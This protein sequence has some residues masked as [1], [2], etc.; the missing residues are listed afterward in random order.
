[1]S[2]LNLI[3][4]TGTTPLF[5]ISLLA[6][7]YTLSFKRNIGVNDK[8]SYLLFVSK[9]EEYSWFMDESEINVVGDKICR[10]ILK[11]GNKY[12]SLCDRSS[13]GLAKKLLDI[14]RNLR[15]P[16]KKVVLSKKQTNDFFKRI[17]PLYNEYGYYTDPVSY[18]LQIRGLNYFQK[19]LYKYLGDLK[20]E[21]KEYIFNILTCYSQNTYTKKSDIDLA[22]I[23]L[24][25]KKD[26][27][28]ALKKHTK[29]YNWLIHDYFGNV[30][31]EQYF[32]NRLKEL[33]DGKNKLELNN[34]IKKWQNEPRQRESEIKTFLS[35]YK[36]DKNLEDAFKSIRDLA[37]LYSETKKFTL[38]Q[39]NIAIRNVLTP[40]AK[41]RKVNLI[42]LYFLNEEELFDFIDGKD[43]NRLNSRK[44]SGVYLMK[45][46]KYSL[47]SKNKEKKYLSK[48]IKFTNNG[49][50][51]SIKGLTASKGNA[52]GRV[53]LV[54]NAS[55]INKVE[56]G[57]ILVAPF[58]TVS[59]VPA[60]EKA[61]A[62]VT[63]LGGITSHAAIVS[64]E[65]KMPCVVGTKNGTNVL[66]DG[67]M[68]EVDAN[69]GI[70]KKIK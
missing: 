2:K 12:F 62:I 56:K 13:S 9:N 43:I 30:L 28:N 37:Y 58:T 61:S 63:D 48:I 24:K 26:Q 21:E 16:N 35:K 36:I 19:K 18:S 10:Q 53:R 27:K 47:L 1:M 38:N 14:T 40:L 60:M 50:I 3:Y 4:K 67:D 25:P 66:S 22:K 20:K 69:K 33:I 45:N 11:E 55:Q 15:Q 31:D 32:S 23:G 51:K 52:K 7:N 46:G 6:E 65:L 8:F 39:V 57:D 49:K 34:L 44:D 5:P 41:E 42:D 29:K 68:V 17:L 70:I 54:L 59:Y 64:R